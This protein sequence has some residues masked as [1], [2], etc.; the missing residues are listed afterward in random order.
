MVDV[1][2]KTSHQHRISLAKPFHANC[3]P[4]AVKI[5]TRIAFG[6]IKFSSKTVAKCAAVVSSA[7]IALVGLLSLSI[8][9]AMNCLHRLI[10]VSD[11]RNSISMN[12]N[13]PDGE[14]SFNN[15]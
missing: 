14:N 15:W 9:K 3:R 8:I 4:F 12:S 7:G 2:A 13:G 11:P 6:I 5:A 1:V 10:L